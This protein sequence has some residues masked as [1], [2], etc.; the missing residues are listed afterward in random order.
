MRWPFSRLEPK[1]NKPLPQL[2]K[3]QTELAHALIT[4]DRKKHELNETV[5]AALRDLRNGEHDA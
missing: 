5:K 3:V 4:L 1:E 2:R